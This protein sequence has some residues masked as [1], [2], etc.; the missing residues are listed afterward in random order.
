MA[1]T[2]VSVKK[3]GNNA[4]RPSGKAGFLLVVREQDI[5]TF[6]RA[7]GSSRVSAFALKA[8]THPI[9]VFLTNT[10]QN[11]Y[12]QMAGEAD[13]RG[14]IHHADGEHP[15]DSESFNDFVENNTNVGLI[16]IQVEPGSTDCKIAG[17]VGNPLFI[18]QDNGQDNNQ[19]KKHALQMAQEFQGP[20]LGRIAKSLVPATEDN[21]VNALLGLPAVGSDGGG[22]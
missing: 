15:G 16:A 5:E 21:E 12:H 22:I 6:T 9:G 14:F 1:Y 8:N 2:F 10:T 20:V 13:A 18:T 19:A 4:G 11:V 3:A 17:L 7:N